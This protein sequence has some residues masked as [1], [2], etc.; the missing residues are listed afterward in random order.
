MP[1]LPRVRAKLRETAVA[2]DALATRVAHLGMPT[3][4]WP[5]LYGI[6]LGSGVFLVRHTSW[7]P[8]V[9]TNK[10]PMADSFKMLFWSLG[11]IGFTALF[12]V[13]ALVFRR[14]RRGDSGGVATVAELN[15]RLRVILPLPILPMLAH[16]GIERDSPKETFFFITVF[17]ALAG[18]A[19][20]AWLRP[21]PFDAGGADDAPPPRRPVLDGL[22]QAAAMFVVTGLW[23]AYGLFF[24]WLSIT[25]HHALNTRTTDLGYYDN[26]FWNSAHGHPLACSFIKAGYHGSAH[27]DPLLV[28]LSPLYLLYQHAEFLL[29]LQSVWLGAGVVPLY[30]LAHHKLGRRLPAMAIAAMYAMYP[31]LQGANMY[32]FHSLTLL[33]PLVLTLLYFLEIG[34]HRRYFVALIPVLL[35]REDASLLMCFVGAYAIYTRVPKM[36]RTGW[37]TI[38]C[39]LVYF[40]VVKR[41]F[42]T[43]ADI[44][45]SGPNSYSFAYYYE[46]LI[47]NH[48]GMG[49]LLVTLFTNPAFVLHV[50]FTEAKVLYLLTL[51]VPLLF[52]PFTVKPGRVMMLY[53]LIFC[54]LAS[55]TA[56]FSPHFQ[57]SSVLL[58]AAFALTPEALKRIEDGRLSFRDIDGPRLSRALVFAA[59]CASVLVSWKFGGVVD[60]AAFR[61]GFGR[62]ARSTT[63]AQEST[64]AWIREQ[65]N[66]IPKTASVGTTNKL[67]AHVSSRRT[68]FFYPEH[69]NADWLFIDESELRGPD[70]DKHNKSVRAGAWVLVSKRDRMALYQRGK[71]A[72]MAPTAAPAVPIPPR[73]LPG[74]K[75]QPA[76]RAR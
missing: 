26:I 64:Y 37:L 20:Y 15:R 42:M 11:G 13:A 46:E 68:A 58:P 22:G 36:V 33:G 47:P 71:G 63:E 21:T 27:F 74:I 75:P 17:A 52:L 4:V 10:V 43:S 39:S 44:L 31:A 73:G 53:G 65:A 32:E 76:K 72:P 12:Y 55:R 41:F 29:V 9:T 49:G 62:V 54:L 5:L 45:M 48:N 59:F 60:N 66:R 25:N 18:A 6:V 16:A 34:A 70:L 67:G 2:M 38:L 14:L 51:F 19:V 23:A 8:V 69:T 7:L 56:V 28:V 3:F 35:C 61:G 57:Y 24:S 40:A 50:V 1:V 30:L